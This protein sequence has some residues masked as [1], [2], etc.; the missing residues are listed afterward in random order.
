MSR[1]VLVVDH[2]YF[3]LEFLSELL[4]K[5]GYLVT[6]AY[7]GKQGFA[8][9]G[10]TPFDIIFTDL[11]IPKVDVRQFIRFIRM[12]Y[13]D[14]HLP[15]VALSGVVME[16]LAVLDKIGADYYIPK[17]PIGPLAVQINEFITEIETQPV[18]PST[19]KKLFKNGNILPR[20]EAV[21]LVTSLQF[22]RAIIENLGVGVII[23][24][25]DTR[26]LNVNSTALDILGKSAV[27]ILNR[28]VSDLFPGLA[29]AELKEALRQV[30]REPERK[31]VAFYTTFNY[32]I[33]RTIVSSILFEN[34]KAGWVVALEDFDQKGQPAKSINA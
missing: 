29:K 20:R 21:E 15:V 28:P 17:G 23:L 32:H 26:V 27:E 1:K 13:P 25:K 3:F 8:K 10:E 18:F 4:E 30:I 7:D 19:A 2:D 16:Q 34:T 9:L 22:H 6:K 12:T 14:Y 5:R 24:D 33:T 11:L 31:K